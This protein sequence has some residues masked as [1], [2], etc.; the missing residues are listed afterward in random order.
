MKILTALTIGLLF[1]GGSVMAQRDV[2]KE[3]VRGHLLYSVL[4]KGD[5]PAIYDPQ[6]IPAK[7]AKELYHD[8]EPVMI[9]SGGKDMHAYSTWHLDRHEIVNDHVDGRAI[10]ATW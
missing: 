1:L 2:K 8:D 4:N 9:V 6:F 7:A 3:M 10:A 5:I